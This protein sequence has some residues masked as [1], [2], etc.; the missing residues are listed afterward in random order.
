M[1]VAAGFTALTDEWE[2]GPDGGLLDSR[3]GLPS[4]AS[5]PLFCGLSSAGW[6]GRFRTASRGLEW[7]SDFCGLAAVCGRRAGGREI[8]GGVD[9][10]PG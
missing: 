3:E 2:K 6:G 5:G 7:N 1:L 9:V 4:L 8:L 10:R